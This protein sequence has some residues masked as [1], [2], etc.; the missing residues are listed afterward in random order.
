M[1]KESKKLGVL[2]CI[3]FNSEGKILAKVAKIEDGNSSLAAKEVLAIEEA[4]D[5]VLCYEWREACFNSD[6]NIVIDAINSLYND[7]PWEIYAPIQKVKEKVND[8]MLARG[9]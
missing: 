4:V 2:W 5:M 1:N 6:S 7:H 8:F 9:N 3:A